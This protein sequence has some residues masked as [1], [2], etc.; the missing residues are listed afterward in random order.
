MPEET[1]YE[2]A[3]RTGISKR[4]FLRFC[5]LTTANLGLQSGMFPRVVKAL[6]TKPRPP[7]YWLNFAACTC[8]TESLIKS[9]H[10]LISN[11]ILSM[12]SLDY[13]ETIQVAAGQ[14][15][16]EVVW[17]GMKKNYG[18]Y[19]LLVEGSVPFK[20][21]GVYCTIAGNTALEH[22][23][24]A[25]EGARL[26]IAVGACASF[27]CVTTA[28]PNPTGC[29]PIYQIIDSKP[30]VNVP[31]CPPIAD[32]IS[33]TLV[34][35]VTF[36]RIPE[37]DGLQRP[38]VFYGTLIHD[39]CYRRSFFDASM[40]V[41]NFDDDAARKGWCLYK[42]GCRGPVTYNACPVVK[43]NNV[44]WPVQSGHPCF[45]CSEPNY[46]DNGM[47]YEHVGG[48]PLPGLS[49]VDKIGAGLAIGTAIATGTH[50]VASSIKKAKHKEQ[51]SKP[52]DQQTKED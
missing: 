28:Y 46:W 49:N 38:K 31:G 14:Q 19:V 17:N 27:G 20:D 6:E 50:L 21:G 43:W 41:E 24:R 12:I 40:Y 52:N 34:Y 44:S 51:P 10:P 42:V 3:R 15:A 16:E 32:V 2:V 5:L 45:G 23:R 29:K 39:K 4:D 1:V 7:V 36:D 37:L 13:M 26:I 25:A 33:G 8:C 48:V 30:V 47:I 9:S 35:L 18:N 22:L 11:A